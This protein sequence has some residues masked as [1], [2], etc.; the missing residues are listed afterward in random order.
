MCFYFHNIIKIKDF[1]F[2]NILLDKKSYEKTLIYD[3][4]YKTT[5]GAKPL[6]IMFNKVD[7]FIRNYGGSKYLVL[8]DAK[9]VVT[10]P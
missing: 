9:K 6:R 2:N 7:G 8:F 1:G 5:T 3:V 4:S 10:F